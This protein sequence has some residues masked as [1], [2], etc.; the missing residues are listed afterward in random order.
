MSVYKR[1]GRGKDK[2]YWVRFRVGKHEIRQS[3]GTT[4]RKLAEEFEQRLREQYYRQYKLGDAP[5]SLWEDA[6]A[7]WFADKKNKRDLKNDREKRAWFDQYLIGAPLNEIDSA[8]ITKIRTLLRGQK[9]KVGKSE[10]TRSDATVNKYLAFLRG[11]LNH[12]HKAGLCDAPPRIETIKTPDYEPRTLTDDE[13]AA[14]FTALEQNAPHARLIVEF[15]FETGLRSANV[16]KLQWRAV[17]IVENDDGTAAGWLTVKASSS[18]TAKPI[19]IPLTARAIAILKAQQGRHDVYV[20][21]DQRGKAPI[22]SIKTA[23]KTAK[24]NAGLA[25]VRFHDLRH[26]WATKAVSRGVPLRVVQELGG[27]KSSRMV[28]RYS[29]L[30]RDDLKRWVA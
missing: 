12:A 19:G 27:W 17:D 14:V 29:H 20:F 18:K 4:D 13:A 10:R 16:R 11:V 24:R 3:A 23:W 15:A 2:N 9:I 25:D 30:S 28:E 6:T 26:T 7:L 22:G 21:T 8:N 5:V 1:A